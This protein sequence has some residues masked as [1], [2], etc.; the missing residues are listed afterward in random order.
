MRW[1]IGIV[2]VVVIAILGYQYFGAR[3]TDVAEQVE[4]DAPPPA[5]QAAE[6]AEAPGEAA[7]ETAEPAAE[8]T[9]EAA[10]QATTEAEQATEEAAEATEQAAEQAE[11]AAAETEQAAEA[12]DEAAE[13]VQTGAQEAT[14]ATQ[15]AAEEALTEAQIAALAQGDPEK[16]E[17]VFNKCKVCH[18]ADEEKNK[19]GPTLV[20]IFGRPAG[21]VEGFKYSDAMKESGVTWDEETLAAY[22]AD[23]KGYIKGNKMAFAGL[24][25]EQEIAD[26]IAYLQEVTAQ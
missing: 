15:E 23:P 14:E 20:G 8:A 24:K 17:R 6:T 9:G 5:E 12:T 13:Q 18:V 4:Q 25:K 3:D 26:L 11:E 16:G 19:V 22:V 21:S 7:E 10:E 2:V 1:I